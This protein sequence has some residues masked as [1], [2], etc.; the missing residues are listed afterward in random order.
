MLALQPFDFAIEVTAG[1]EN[2]VADSISRI[3]WAITLPNVDTSDDFVELL[4]ADSESA[5][6][7]GSDTS[8]TLL[9]IETLKQYKSHETDIAKL[10]QWI[11]TE[12]LPTRE[13]LQAATP[14]L[15]TMTQR[16]SELSYVD[17]LLAL[18]A[19]DGSYWVVV[20]PSLVEEVIDEAHQGP[21]TAHERVQ[22]VLRRLLP[23]YYWPRIKRDE[24][25]HLSI[26]PI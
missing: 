23:S 22:K 21:G 1:K 11:A 12:T 7:V 25:I 4:D 14:Y 19:E 26:C 16:L 17:S 13:E 18:Q 8:L 2:V 9:A 5:S 24:P 15:R 3:P 6:K 20:P 10:Q